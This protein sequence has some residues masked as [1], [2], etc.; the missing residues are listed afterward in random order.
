MGISVDQELANAHDGVYTY[1]IQGTVVHEMGAL[2]LAEGQQSKFAQI[3]FYDPDEQATH[4]ARI[5]DNILQQDQLPEIQT[6]LENLNRFCHLYKN[7]REHE[8]EQGSTEDLTI[9]LKAAR[10]VKGHRQW[11]YDLPSANEVVI[12]LPGVGTA[13]EPRDIC[14]EGHDGCLKKIFE[15][16]P[17]YDPLQYVLLHPRG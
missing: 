5:F 13:T 4:H 14:I 10:E 7:T 16:Y 12:L 8:A 6:T 9:V 11:Q 2:W 1:Q 15:T 17:A 3:Y